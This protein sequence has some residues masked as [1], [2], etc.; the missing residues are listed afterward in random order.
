MDVEC[1]HDDLPAESALR[2]G[3]AVSSKP[4]HAPSRA[5]TLIELLVVVAIIGVLAGMLLPAVH[6][7]REAALDGSCKSNLRQMGL[8]LQLYS[9][10]Y[11]CF[12]AHQWIRPDNSRWRWFNCLG[13]MLKN[14]KVESCPAVSWTVG[15]NNSYGY[16]YKYLGSARD[17][18]G[19]PTKP[20]EHFPV[21]GVRAPERT[22]AFGDSDGTG[23]EE[24]YEPIPEN[25][26]SSSLSGTVRRKRIGNHGYTLD[27]TYIPT[28]STSQAEPYSD[29]AAPTY[30]STRHRGA[31]NVCFV[32][33]HVERIKPQDAYRDNSLWN[34]LGVEDPKLDWHVHYKAP[35]FRY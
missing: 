6:R 25:Q 16:N 10:A 8:A 34:G 27:P 1:P 29:G 9:N 7:A 14:T 13:A 30:L 19:S 18:G 35:G 22:I 23:T 21:R 15:R 4:L 3:Y 17:N 2:G 26:A 11:D 20:W 5:F 28:W 32:D 24:P 12:P 33:G 31:A